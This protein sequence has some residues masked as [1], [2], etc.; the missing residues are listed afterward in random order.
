MIMLAQICWLLSL[1]FIVSTTALSSSTHHTSTSTI[2]KT[3]TSSSSTHHTSTST[4]K[5]STISSSSTHHTSSSSTRSSTVP[6]SSTP[7][8]FYLVAEDTGSTAFDGSYFK[9]IPDPF[10]VI[11]I[12]GDDAIQFGEK[13]SDGA[14]SFTLNADGTL[15]K[16]TLKPFFP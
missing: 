16:Y 6:P 8:T 15:R 7:S 5:K 14:A 2:K 3:S 1:L 11:T 9:L 10:P 12:S 4:T 13:N